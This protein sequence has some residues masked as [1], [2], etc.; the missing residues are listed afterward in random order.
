MEGQPINR[1]ERLREWYSGSGDAQK[2]VDKEA[3]ATAPQRLERRCARPWRLRSATAAGS[4]AGAPS[5]RSQCRW[6]VEGEAARVHSADSSAQHACRRQR[7]RRRRPRAPPSGMQESP[8]SFFMS[9]LVALK[10]R[11]SDKPEEPKYPLL[12]VRRRCWKAAA[13][14]LARTRKCIVPPSPL[15]ARDPSPRAFDAV[16][17]VAP[18]LA[19][20]PNRST[21]EER[22]KRIAATSAAKANDRKL[23]A[24]FIQV[25]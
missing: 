2:A 16:R 18:H 20:Q 14:P 15:R 1:K 3:G 4:A 7:R 8:P 5:A 22:C 6:V 21:A 23:Y 11:S 17:R 19:S 13:G 9:Y 10:N 24:S 25:Y 12:R